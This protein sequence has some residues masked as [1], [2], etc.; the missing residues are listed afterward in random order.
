V[1]ASVLTSSV[2]E[3]LP[4]KRDVLWYPTLAIA[5]PVPNLPD[6]SL[7]YLDFVARGAQSKGPE[8]GTDGRAMSISGAFD[9]VLREHFPEAESAPDGKKWSTTRALEGAPRREVEFS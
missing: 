5:G 6:H 7:D 9:L 4:N 1:S 3:K 2:A 8:E